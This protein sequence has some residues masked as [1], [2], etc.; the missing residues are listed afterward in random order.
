M[1][2]AGAQSDMLIARC[3][4]F[5]AAAVLAVLPAWGTVYKLVDRKGQVTYSNEPAPKGF[6]G[7]VTVVDVDPTKNVVPS[8]SDAVASPPVQPAERKAPRVVKVDARRAELAA[9]RAKA[10]AARRAFENLRDNPG[11]DDW[12]AHA[13]L[14]SGATRAPSPDYLERLARFEQDAIQAE[15]RVAQLERAGR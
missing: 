15:Q 12:I 3:Q 14:P 2:V 11:P 6:E 7:E 5:L 8:G 4:V 10:S 9:A 1:R 13:P